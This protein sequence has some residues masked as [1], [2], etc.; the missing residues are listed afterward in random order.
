MA[1]RPTWRASFFLKAADAWM[2]LGGSVAAA[3]LSAASS[4]ARE[5]GRAPTR[6]RSA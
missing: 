6:T 3:I 2:S 1:W 4:S 5:S